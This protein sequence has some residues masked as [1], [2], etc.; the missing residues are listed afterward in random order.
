MPALNRVLTLFIN[1]SRLPLPHTATSPRISK[2]KGH[3]LGHPGVYDQY[4]KDAF[5]GKHP[6]AEAPRR[7]AGASVGRERRP[8]VDHRGT[9]N[10]SSPDSLTSEMHRHGGANA[11]PR[12]FPGC[13][14][15]SGCGCS[16]CASSASAF[17]TSLRG[18]EASSSSSSS[19]SKAARNANRNAN[20]GSRPSWDDGSAAEP[21]TRDASYYAAMRGELTHGHAR[22]V[23]GTWAVGRWGGLRRWGVGRV[24][25]LCG[26]I[27]AEV[28]RG[29]REEQSGVGGISLAKC[30][31]GIV[32]QWQDLESDDR[33]LMCN[34]QIR[35]R[36]VC[37]VI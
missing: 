26:G 22:C 29:T 33:W 28:R 8:D 6:D 11:A 34:R 13:T 25:W 18:G 3:D 35:T 1:L 27:G 4:G 23:R 7:F 21:A 9:G 19:L 10:G 36:C 37:F 5:Y 32:S 30:N 20:I 16:A 14:G 31:P 12:S 17:Q 2:P 15:R 24:V